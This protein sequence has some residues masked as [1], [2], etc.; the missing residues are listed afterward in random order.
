MQEVSKSFD[1]TNL[2]DHQQHEANSFLN[3]LSLLLGKP[4]DSTH[5]LRV[6]SSVFYALRQ[7]IT[8]F[9]SMHLVS[10]LPLIL[11]GIYVDSWDIEQPLSGADTMDEFLNQVKNFSGSFSALDFA[12]DEEAKEKIKIVFIALRR[13]VSEQELDQIRD[14]LPKEIAEMV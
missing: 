11:K 10:Q 6:L 1:M 2:F 14:E 7:R 5:A 13:Y 9:E 4:D 12:D 3:D 8:V